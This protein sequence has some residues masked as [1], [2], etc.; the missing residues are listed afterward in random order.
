MAIRWDELAGDVEALRPWLASAGL[1]EGPDGR[2]TVEVPTAFV[3]DA[4]RLRLKGALEAAARARGYARVD[5]VVA[6]PARTQAQDGFASFRVTPGNQLA[7]AALTSLLPR[8]RPELHPLVLHGPAGCGKSHLLG[9]LTAALRSK[10]VQPV[11]AT[12]VPR[13]ARRLGLTAREGGLPA[14]RKAFRSARLLVLDEAHKLAGKT[15][16]QAEIGHALDALAT[17]GGLAVLALREAPDRL[18]GVSPALRSRFQSG[19]VIQMN[20]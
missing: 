14:F 4:L 7:Y 15:K 20:N 19:L 12:A 13:L 11:I 6:G 2:L 1:R 3:R 10:G 16:V 18:E 5:V 9:A 8:F 17:G